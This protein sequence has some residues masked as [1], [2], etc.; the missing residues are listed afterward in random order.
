MRLRDGN[1]PD[2]FAVAVDQPYFGG[3]NQIV[4]SRFGLCRSSIKAAAATWRKNTIVLLLK[5]SRAIGPGLCAADLGAR[6]DR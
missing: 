1:D 2:L 5:S 6:H 4:N 3:A